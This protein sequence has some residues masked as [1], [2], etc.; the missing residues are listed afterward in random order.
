MYLIRAEAN[1]ELGNVGAAMTDVNLVRARHFDPPKPLTASSQA[2]ARELIL[3]ERLFEFAAEAKRR[4]DLIRAGR[5]TAARRFKEAR[6][7]YR[8]LMPIP[9]T[10]LQTNPLLVQNAGY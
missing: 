3:R 9:E 4:R 7:P 6:E 2:E 10:Q 1:N 5:Y 8:I